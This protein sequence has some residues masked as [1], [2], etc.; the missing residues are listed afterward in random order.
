MAKIANCDLFVVLTHCQYQK[1]NYLNRFNI[2]DKW[3]TMRV[4]HGLDPI[5]TKHYIDPEADWDTIK[6]K[7]PKYEHILAQFDDCITDSLAD[8]NIAIIKKACIMLGIQTEIIIDDPTD[9]TGT[10]R[11]LEICQN[12]QATCYLSG[13]SG[14]S[15]L[16][17]TQFQEADIQIEFHQCQDRRPLVECLYDK[18]R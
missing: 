6:R 4:P 2:T 7:L 18:I 10:S 9:K 3:Y 12:H 14:Q 5:D 17:M 8:T 13:P 11:L 16:D 15:Y 1:N